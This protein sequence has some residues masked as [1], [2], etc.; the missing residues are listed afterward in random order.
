LFDDQTF[1]AVRTIVGV[2]ADVH[3]HG[4][5]EEPL[6][7]VYI[8]HAQHPDVIRPSIVVRAAVPPE[9]LSAAIRSRLADYDPR[10][11]VLKIRPMDDVV[12]GALSRPRFNLLLL[13][14]FAVIALALA[15]VGIH[16]VLAYLVTERTREIGIR[17]ALG[18]QAA[19]VLGLV[20]R[21]ALGPVLAGG[22]VGLAVSL[23]ATRAVRSMLYGVTPLDGVSFM[24]APVLLCAVAL[25]ACYVPARRAIAVDPLVALRDE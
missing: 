1:G 13:S 25:V 4:V 19:D 9:T 10:L 3:V 2:V 22:A 15:S 12:S 6:P 18:A 7:A 8:P 17:V 20:L 24:A 14:A 21:D 16:G 11:L 23:V 5:G